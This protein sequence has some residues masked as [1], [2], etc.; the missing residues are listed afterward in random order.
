MIKIIAIVIGGLLVG[1]GLAYGT[2]VGIIPVAIPFGPAAEARAAADRAKPPVTVMYPTKE[3]VV[4]L[5]DKSA[6]KYLKVALTLEFIDTRLKDPPAAAAV[7]QQ[8]TD[9]ASE[10]SPYGAVI[11]DAL[12]T[13]LSSKSSGDL[14]KSDGKDQLKNDLIQNVNHALHDQEKVVNV[15]LT[16]FII[17]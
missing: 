5:T 8:Q 13:T 4:N 9:F 11:E 3:R 10:M 1:A 6:S 16:E 17:Q 7:G 15:Y 14:L 12:T 2:F